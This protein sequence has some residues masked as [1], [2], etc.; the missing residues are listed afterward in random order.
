MT[1]FKL[2][3]LSHETQRKR[4]TGSERE[5]GTGKIFWEEDVFEMG[6][7]IVN[8]ELAMWG[9]HTIKA[10]CTEIMNQNGMDTQI[11]DQREGRKGR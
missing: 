3:E 1:F 2:G 8:P 5:T 9:M 11:G 10:F 7:Y 4:I 6:K